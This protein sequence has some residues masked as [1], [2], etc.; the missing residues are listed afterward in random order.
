[1]VV[2]TNISKTC[3]VTVMTS[4]TGLKLSKTSVNLDL[5]GTKTTKI[6]AE[7]EPSTASYKEIEWSSSN[8]KV[9][10]VD[11]E[12]N[13]TAKNS[14]TANIIATIK[15]T[16]INKQCTI[17]VTSGSTSVTLNKTSANIDMSVNK[18][19][20]LKA[21]VKPESLS[22]K[23]VTWSSSNTKVATVDESGLVLAKSNGTTQITAKTSNNKTAKCMIKVNTNPTSIVLDRNT[24]TIEG[25]R[26]IKLNATVN[27][28]KASNKTITWSSSNTK[29][30]T[31]D[32]NGKVVG[33]SKGTVTITAKTSNGKADTCKVT[34]REGYWEVKKGKYI[35][36]Y[37]NGTSKEWTIS[38]YTA[39]NKLKEQKVKAMDP[40][41]F[42]MIRKHRIYYAGFDQFY[43]CKDET[44]N[45]IAIKNG[46]SPYA[47][48]VDLENTR[49]SI[50]KNNNGVWEPYKFSRVN[51]G[52]KG[53]PSPKGLF[54]ING[55]RWPI[56][57][58]GLHYWVEFGV[59]GR[60]NNG[61][62][63]DY[64]HQTGAKSL[65][66]KCTG[67]CVT[68]FIDHAKWIYYNCGR[69]TPVLIW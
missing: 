59:K 17:T 13:I 47:V 43:N 39:W 24:L 29:V 14:G 1:E 26:E 63:T 46:G 60:N 2:G 33:K 64:L 41:A 69:G 16:N 4:P 53:A 28:S 18:S 57:S 8:T 6:R 30:A 27:P 45:N 11:K 21:T 5:S 36:H 52:S 58:D 38:E 56:T 40:T 22:N 55:G 51:I 31:V 23:S 62:Q 61:E 32:K 35:Y 42:K 48:T 9:A 54:Y 34:V 20:Q 19:I 65:G 10:E 49:E 12:G 66:N 7:V 15:G 37:L 25:I 44:A 3:K 68:T 67:G 50:F